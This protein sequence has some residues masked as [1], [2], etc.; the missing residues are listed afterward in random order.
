MNPVAMTFVI[1]RTEIS[2]DG[3]QTSDPQFSSPV[4]YLLNYCGLAFWNAMD[5]FGKKKDIWLKFV[6]TLYF[7]KKV[8]LWGKVIGVL[9]Q[10]RK[11]KMEGKQ[12]VSGKRA[13]TPY[14]V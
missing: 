1:S 7:Q 2:R 14:F 10:T 9:L 6:Y 8:P 12:N 11:P 4:C 13:W 3:D 5:P